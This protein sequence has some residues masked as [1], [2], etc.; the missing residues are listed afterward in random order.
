MSP[1]LRPKI[2]IYNWAFV[3]C[4]ASQNN[5]IFKVQFCWGKSEENGCDLKNSCYNTSANR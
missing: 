4:S 3:C 1:L 2:V 5:V